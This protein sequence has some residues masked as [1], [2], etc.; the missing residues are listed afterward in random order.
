MK[1]LS[2]LKQLLSIEKPLIIKHGLISKLVVVSYLKLLK[3]MTVFYTKKFDFNSYNI[4]KNH[5]KIIN[6]YVYILL[7]KIIRL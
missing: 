1:Y 6:K 3:N 7:S 5:L 4:Y 2:H